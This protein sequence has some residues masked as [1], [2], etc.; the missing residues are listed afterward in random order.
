MDVSLEPYWT[1]EE[2]AVWARCRD[3]DVVYL[4]QTPAL[5]SRPAERNK[6]LD[7][8]IG[9]AAMAARGR[10]R[11]IER[12]L[13]EAWGHPTPLSS[14]I[15]PYFASDMQCGAESRTSN[16]FA[17]EWRAL[18]EAYGKAP[19]SDQRKVADA[20][21]LAA[22]GR[23][24]SELTAQLP[25]PFDVLVANV[26]AMPRGWVRSFGY[27]PVFPVCDYLLEL[28]RAGRLKA[29]GNLPSEPLARE[30]SVSDWSGLTI[31]LA[32]DTERL[33]VWRLGNN[34]RVGDGDIENVR[35]A[36]EDVLKAF[37]ADPPPPPKPTPIQ[38]T[39]EDARRVILDAMASSGGFI[40][41]KNSAKIVRS[42]YPNFNATRAMELTR[43]LT[44]NTKRGPRGPRRKSSQ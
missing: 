38:P 39:V 35:V 20:L 25:A 18:A 21:D 37:P 5:D 33:R 36:R 41:Q 24:V 6:Y 4:L 23:S 16:D 34:P 8:R 17:P 13:W 30:L 7:L 10:G 26:L 1:I 2:I 12:E 22:A 31:S 27:I 43:E 40:S 19:L 44:G 3:S 28:L 29:I 14:L 9:H 15:A 42:V 11:N 32:T